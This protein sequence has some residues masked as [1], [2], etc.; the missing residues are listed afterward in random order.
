MIERFIVE[1]PP[2]SD[3]IGSWHETVSVKRETLKEVYQ[4]AL[5]RSGLKGENNHEI[6]ADLGCGGGEFTKLMLYLMP[7]NHLV[8]SVDRNPFGLALLKNAVETLGEEVISA[9]KDAVSAAL[10]TDVAERSKTVPVLADY[11]D[12]VD[13]LP[14][15]S[16]DAAFCMLP[17][18]EY[19]AKIPGL[20]EYGNNLIQ[21]AVMEQRLALLFCKTMK[22]LK[23]GGM[24]TLTSA[25]RAKDIIE[26][27]KGVQEAW[28]MTGLL[29][30]PYERHLD[31]AETQHIVKYIEE[32][33]REKY[34][35]DEKQ[36]IMHLRFIKDSDPRK[37][38]ENRQ[39]ENKLAM[40]CGNI[41]AGINGNLVRINKQK[42][43]VEIG[44]F[45]IAIDPLGFI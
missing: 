21:E 28:S 27:G 13:C 37:K 15:N 31:A 38:Q 45:E 30:I 23:P 35:G 20:T 14:E 40:R 43:T 33:L 26:Y 24:I 25:I 44:R 3:T 1:I 19:S 4:P 36:W 22:A 18:S 16:I 17:G 5:L 8:F 29:H 11:V 41:K 2:V 42:L 32:V 6:I 12:F 7:Q 39:L 10:K 34:E 9:D